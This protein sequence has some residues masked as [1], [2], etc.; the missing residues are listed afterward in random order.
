[1]VYHGTGARGMLFIELKCPRRRERLAEL[2]TRSSKGSMMLTSR[3]YWMMTCYMSLSELVGILVAHATHRCP[4]LGDSLSFKACSL[5]RCASASL[6]PYAL[7][8][9]LPGLAIR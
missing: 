2:S 9:P 5:S 7:L 6:L 4:P 8:L 1:M 3:S